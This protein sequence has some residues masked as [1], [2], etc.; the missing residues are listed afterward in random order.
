MGTV[1]IKLFD[2]MMIE[3]K[4]AR[5]VPQLKKNLISVGAL[6]AQGLSGTLGEDILKMSNGSLVFLK[7]IRRNNLYYLKSS[8]VIEKLT[9]SEYLK[10]DSTKL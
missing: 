3:L 6:E 1:C 4:D 2:G 7:G 10:D 8:A 5:Y 9:A